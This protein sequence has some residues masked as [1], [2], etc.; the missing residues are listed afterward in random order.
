M[1]EQ[2]APQTRFAGGH[3]ASFWVAVLH[4]FFPDL[5][6]PFENI[7]A[8]DIGWAWGAVDFLPMPLGC[9]ISR[10]CEGLPRREQ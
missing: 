2:T 7:E 10:K 6:M 9:A 3:G 8:L 5:D 1:P 4:V